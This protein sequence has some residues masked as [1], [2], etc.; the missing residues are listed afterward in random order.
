MADKLET[1]NYKTDAPHI[2]FLQVNECTS[3]DQVS[4]LSERIFSKKLREIKRMIT[5]LHIPDERAACVIISYWRQKLEIQQVLRLSQSYYSSGNAVYMYW[6]Q[7]IFYENG[8]V[9]YVVA[10]Q[11]GCRSSEGIWCKKSS[12]ES[13]AMKTKKSSEWQCFMHISCGRVK[14]WD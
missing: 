7:Y 12:I 1:F 11:I 8:A 14:I 5:L 9:Y 3:K 13:R 6:R 2:N 10:N 4:L